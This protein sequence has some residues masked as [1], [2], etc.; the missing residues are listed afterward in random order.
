MDV[1][2]IKKW[3]PHRYPFLLVDRVIRG[4]TGDDKY[5]SSCSGLENAGMWASWMVR[6]IPGWLSCLSPRNILIFF[7][8]VHEH[9]HPSAPEALTKLIL[10]FLICSVLLL[11]SLRSWLVLI[12]ILP[13]CVLNLL[14]S[15]VCGIVCMLGPSVH[16]VCSILGVLRGSCVLL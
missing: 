12:R 14:L 7:I 6:S 9:H 1:T 11:A 13:I 4:W 15:V 2:E 10:G 5:P 3:L 8:N 16:F